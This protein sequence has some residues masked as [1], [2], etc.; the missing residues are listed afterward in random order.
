MEK[1]IHEITKTASRNYLYQY[2]DDIKT[3]TINAEYENCNPKTIQLEF[4]G[5]YGHDDRPEFKTQ[6]FIVGESKTVAMPPLEFKDP[7]KDRT[8]PLR[9]FYLVACNCM[10]VENKDFLIRATIIFE[11]NAKTKNRND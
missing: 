6:K 8:L 3:I 1:E 7:Y 11:V 9:R 5:D 2:S 4:Y 10:G